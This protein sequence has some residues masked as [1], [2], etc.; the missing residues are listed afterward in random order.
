MFAAVF[1]GVGLGLFYPIIEFV[2]SDNTDFSGEVDGQLGLFQD[3]FGFL[4]IP[5]SFEYT[6]AVAIGIFGLRFGLMFLVS[7]LRAILQNDYNRWLRQ[8]SYDLSLGASMSYVDRKGSDEILNVIMTQTNVA[9]SAIS[10]LIRL[11]K[12]SV[13]VLVILGLIFVIAPLFAAVATVFLAVVTL[14]VRTVVESGYDIG[15]RLADANERVQSISQSGILGAQEARLFNMEDDLREDFSDALGLWFSSRV[16]RLRNQ[17]AI[18]KGYRFLTIASVFLVVYVAT[19]LSTLTLGSISVL[20]IALYRLAPKISQL[21]NLVYQIESNLPHVVRT[22]DF[23][24]E[25]ERHQEDDSGTK[26]VSGNLRT[27]GFEDVTFRYGSSNDTVLQD[28]SFEVE[29]SEFV[30]L[31]GKSGAGKSTIASLIARSYTPDSG[32]IRANG[33]DIDEYELSA[34]RERVAMVPQN[35]HLFDATLGE[36]IAVGNPDASV[37]EIESVAEIACVTEFLDELPRGYET[38]V[39]EDAV[40]LSGGQRQRVALARA[41]LKDADVLVLDEA[42]SDLDSNIEGEVQRNIESMDEEY[43]LVAIAHSLSTVKNADRIYTLKD[44][45]I[46]EAGSH[47]ELLALDGTYAELYATQ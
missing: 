12:H 33:T 45:C 14:V 27:L 15:D 29:R 42:T 20:L 26:P 1:E 40:Q 18:S 37:D 19:T 22:H 4:G 13:V 28:I 44:G 23:L 6:I 9:A 10:S 34:W 46:A 24:D 39:G 43:I 32:V 7:W 31:V 21:N 25:L 3:A 47:D 16:T 17:E 2:G 11:V 38:A 35:P 5:F 41:L 30:A 8:R 36:N